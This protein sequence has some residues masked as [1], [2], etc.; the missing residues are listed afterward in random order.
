[1]AVARRGRG[2]GGAR[3][4]G[5]RRGRVNRWGAQVAGAGTK[6]SKPAPSLA[7]R[8]SAPCSTPK[9]CR[10]PSDECCLCC[11]PACAVVCSVRCHSSQ[12]CPALPPPKRAPFTHNSLAT[13]QRF[14]TRGRKPLHACLRD[15]CT[16]PTTTTAFRA[17]SQ[18]RATQS[19]A[20]AHNGWA[21]GRQGSGFL[22]WI[23]IAPAV[24][25][26]RPGVPASGSATKSTLAWG[27]DTSC[28]CASHPL[29]T[30]HTT[31][32]P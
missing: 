4:R 1:M 12:W 15:A 28:V 2:H 21:A 6:S 25:A 23:S 26:R 22:P 7:D 18:P 13:E 14:R 32:S 5:A 31:P 8:G 16:P 24:Q 17:R 29:Y 30:P 19:R 11:L 20:L 27:N 3:P 10:K 9:P